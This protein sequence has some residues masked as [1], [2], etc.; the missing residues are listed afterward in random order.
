[1][2]M[3]CTFIVPLHAIVH[4]FTVTQVDKNSSRGEKLPLGGSGVQSLLIIT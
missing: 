3:Q 1:M 2:Y 4:Q